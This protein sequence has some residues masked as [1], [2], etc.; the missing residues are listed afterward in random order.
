MT[1]GDKQDTFTYPVS[2]L[3]LGM[4]D[5]IASVLLL[6]PRVEVIFAISLF[7]TAFSCD[8]T[9][10]G[11]KS[12]IRN[13]LTD[14]NC[15][16]S[17]YAL[18]RRKKHPDWKCPSFD[19]AYTIIKDETDGNVWRL[20]AKPNIPTYPTLQLVYCFERN[21]E[22]TW[23]IEMVNLTDVMMQ[24]SYCCFYLFGSTLKYNGKRGKPAFE[25]VRMLRT[26]TRDTFNLYA[27]AFNHPHLPMKYSISS[28]REDDIAALQIQS[29]MNRGSEHWLETFLPI[30]HRIRFR[31]L[32]LHQQ[33]PFNIRSKKAVSLVIA[34][35]RE[36]DLLM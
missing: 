17:R 20:T 18:S 28:V 32:F 25:L 22:A 10:E 26:R 29:K 31:Q 5:D 21:F 7:D 4:G 14:G 8:G 35:E 34:S 19:T 24:G 15:S 13:C 12:D 30:E 3:Y 36:R 16:R 11:Q 33:H 23:P 6:K 1:I 2:V 27:L 9:M